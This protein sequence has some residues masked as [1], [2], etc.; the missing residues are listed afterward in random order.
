M[1]SIIILGASCVGKSTLMRDVFGGIKKGKY[2]VLTAVKNPI[3]LNGWSYLPE[4][5]GNQ[6][7]AAGQKLTDFIEKERFITDVS[8]AQPF[9]LYVI[10]DA[11]IIVL[12]VDDDILRR[13]LETRKGVTKGSNTIEDKLKTCIKY[14]DKLRKS[15][16][17]KM[18]YEELE[19]YLRIKLNV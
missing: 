15:E 16:H 4:L 12:D 7:K 19:D 3:R 13:N 8:V 18:G 11:D 5:T 6:I 10:K 1:K 14:R 9:G 2:G 17:P